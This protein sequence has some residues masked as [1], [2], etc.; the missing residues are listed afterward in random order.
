MKNYNTKLS[1]ISKIH[2]AK[3]NFKSE[4]HGPLKTSRGG[5][6]CLEGQSIPLPTGRTRRVFIVKIMKNEKNVVSPVYK[7][8]SNKYEKRLSASVLIKHCT[9]WQGHCIN[10]KNCVKMNLI[11]VL[12]ILVPT[13]CLWAACLV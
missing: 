12:D 5:I 4:Q 2:I 13:T 7:K 6:R 9:C 3:Y 11:E 1:T 10:H 8:W